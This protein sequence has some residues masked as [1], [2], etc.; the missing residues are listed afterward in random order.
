[1]SPAC[2]TDLVVLGADVA[3]DDLGVGAL[4]GRHLER[5]GVGDVEAGGERVDVRNAPRRQRRPAT[6]SPSRPTGR[7]R[8]A[9]RTSA[10]DRRR[11]G[12]PLRARPHMPVVADV[13]SAVRHRVVVRRRAWWSRRRRRASHGPGGQHRDPLEQRLLAVACSGTS[14]TRPATAAT[15]APSSPA[16][17]RIALH[18]RAE[19]QPA[20]RRWRRY[21]GL[22]PKRSRASSSSLLARCPRSRTRRSR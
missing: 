15:A 2:S 8:P 19:H 12:A 18:L 16:S 4:V 21:S 6:P 17:A 10:G 5:R 22:A 1:M 9:R 11:A 14:C 13:G 7:R 20:R 3:G